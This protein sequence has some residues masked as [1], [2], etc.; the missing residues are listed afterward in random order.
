MCVV[1][2]QNFRYVLALHL[3]HPRSHFPVTVDSILNDENVARNHGKNLS[4]NH[5][6]WSIVSI[7]DDD[8]DVFFSETLLCHSAVLFLRHH[9][10]E[11]QHHR[12]CDR[13]R[14]HLPIERSALDFV[15]ESLE[16]I[17]R[18]HTR[19]KTIDVL[20]RVQCEE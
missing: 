20:N 8:D 3:R 4:K 7:D 2:K 15:L 9:L 12:R 14:P 17:R 18:F 1:A 10:V 11:L 19:A 6:Q 13:H 5:L 16:R